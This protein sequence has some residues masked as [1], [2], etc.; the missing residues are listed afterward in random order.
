MS[1]EGVPVWE[2]NASPTTE[3]RRRSV[4][5]DSSPKTVLVPGDSE[6]GECRGRGTGH[7]S[8]QEKELIAKDLPSAGL[9]PTIADETAEQHR[10]QL[11]KSRRISDSRPPT[12][13][14]NKLLEEESEDRIYNKGHGS[15]IQNPDLFDDVKRIKRKGPY[16]KILCCS[17]SLSIEL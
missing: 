16:S 1:D 12:S 3:K 15:G 5:F 9:P 14:G 4:T 7:F 6:E 2:A 10:F 13:F 11:T 8:S 17:L